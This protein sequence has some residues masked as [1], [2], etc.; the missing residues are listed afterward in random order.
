[1]YK[2]T[3]N[4]YEITKDGEVFNKTYNR[5]IKYELNDKG[6]YRVII[7]GERYFIH[8]LVAQKYVP[9]P[10]NKPHINHKNGIKTDN[11]AENLEWVTHKENIHHALNSGL[12]PIGEQCSWTKLKRDD[13]IFIRKNK[14][15][16]Q[17]EL[18]KKFN[19]SPSTISDIR[20]YKSWKKVRVE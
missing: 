1:M 2:L 3:L 18:S 6:Y 14:E 8:K 4:D 11:R 13:V 10:L 15:I 7:G 19:V 5:K 9:N 12:I 17:K 16:S 20:N